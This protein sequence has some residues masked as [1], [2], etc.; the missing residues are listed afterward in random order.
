M[1]YST[2]TKCKFQQK[3]SKIYCPVKLIHQ[4]FPSYRLSS[5]SGNTNVTPTTEVAFVCLLRYVN[6]KT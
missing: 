2:V 6:L 3:K 4:Y 5:S 1:Y